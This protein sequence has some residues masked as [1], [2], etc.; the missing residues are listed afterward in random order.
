MSNMKHLKLSELGIA[1]YTGRY[2]GPL[3]LADFKGVVHI[4]YAWSNLALFESFQLGIIY[5]IPS[6]KFIESICQNRRFFWSPPFNKSLLHLSEWYNDEHKS[7]FVY[8]DSWQDLQ[9]KIKNTNY[10]AKRNHIIEFGKK[11]KKTTLSKWRRLLN[12]K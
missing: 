1:S 8:F 9:N 12:V 7:L 11:H 6:K 4:P 5:F 10:E 3:E 2:N